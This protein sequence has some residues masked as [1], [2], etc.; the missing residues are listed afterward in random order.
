M[1]EAPVDIIIH[2]RESGWSGR[3]AG[4]EPEGIWLMPSRGMPLAANQQPIQLAVVGRQIPHG[5]KLVSKTDK[6]AL[7]EPRNFITTSPP[8]RK[9]MIEAT[10][11]HGDGGRS[12][13]S[14]PRTGKPFTW[15]RRT[16]ERD[17][18][19]EVGICLT[20]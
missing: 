20:R 1:V 9:G 19:Q 16:V 3:K 15:R 18:K 4:G 5:V 10:D 13:R 7:T 8:A 12:P 17:C 11:D 14:S 6:G 2:Q